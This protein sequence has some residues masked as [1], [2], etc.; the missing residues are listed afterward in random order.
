MRR[1]DLKVKLLK[2]KEILLGESLSK[3]SSSSFG[4]C[5]LLGDV[6]WP[7]PPPGPWVVVMVISPLLAA[8]LLRAEAAET[9][10]PFIG[11][12]CSC[13][14]LWCLSNDWWETVEKQAV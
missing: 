1:T 12:D 7:L 8:S 6:S 2:L 4:L 9:T 3:S 5:R 13:L 10:G 11:E 14:S